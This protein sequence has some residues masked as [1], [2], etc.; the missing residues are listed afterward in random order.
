MFTEHS[1]LQASHRKNVI[2]IV[3]VIVM[4]PSFH[5]VGY[6]V[7]LVIISIEFGWVGSASRWARLN[8]II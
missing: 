8:W 1:K 6:W 7:E 5:S 3:R 4:N 2:F